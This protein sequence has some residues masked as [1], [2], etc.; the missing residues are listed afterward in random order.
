MLIGEGFQRSFHDLMSQA[1]T[2]LLA[3]ILGA[4]TRPASPAPQVSR[5]PLSAALLCSALCLEHQIMATHQHRQIHLSE[6][7]RFESQD[8][9]AAVRRQVNGADRAGVE[10]WRDAAICRAQVDAISS[11]KA[12][13]RVQ[14]GRLTQ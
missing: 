3:P 11:I 5:L 7:F 1:I 8:R 4:F 13:R 12:Q 6:R 9:K 2:S 10:N 14:G